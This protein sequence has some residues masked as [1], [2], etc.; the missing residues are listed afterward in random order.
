MPPSLAIALKEPGGM[1][2]VKQPLLWGHWLSDGVARAR[3]LRKVKL[4]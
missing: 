3:L 4:D 2:V 1:I